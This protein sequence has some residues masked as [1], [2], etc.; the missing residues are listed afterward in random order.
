MESEVIRFMTLCPV[1]TGIINN[2]NS[3]S[4]L[5]N[6]ED[7]TNALTKAGLLNADRSKI[8]GAAIKFL[9]TDAY[10]S[11]YSKMDPALQNFIHWINGHKKIPST[12]NIKTKVAALFPGGI[13][14]LANLPAFRRDR[15]NVILSLIAA[16]AAP[17]SKGTARQQL[18]IAFK[19]I[20]ALYRH[21]QNP[22]EKLEFG[23]L[24]DRTV[25]LPKSIFPLP[26][27][28][29]AARKKK[30][31]LESKKRAKD[32]QRKNSIRSLVAKIS[33]NVGTSQ[34][35]ADAYDKYLVILRSQQVALA[36]NLLS[37]SAAPAG[38]DVLPTPPSLDLVK[39]VSFILPARIADGLSSSAKTTLQRLHID[40]ST[41]DVPVVRK[42]IAAE[43]KSLSNQLHALQSKNA[44]ITFI[45]ST[46]VLAAESV[47]GFELAEISEIV[48]GVPGHCNSGNGTAEE[49][50][51]SDRWNTQGIRPVLYIGDLQK[52]R[53]TLNRY[54]LGDIAHIEN[55]LKG[56]SKNNVLRRLD[57]TVETTVD[58]T[59]TESE[60]EKDL[61]T[62]DQF[63]LQT[64]AAKT[65]TQDKSFDAGLTVSG[66]YGP[67]L[68]ATATA[69]LSL[70][71]TRAQSEQTS[72]NYARDVI[73][74]TVQK[75]K[76][77]NLNS[78]T[79]T[80]T[81]EIK[82]LNKHELDNSTGA[83]HIRGIYQWVN[84]IYR[85]QVMNYG[86]RAML[87][88]TIPDPA[89]FYRYAFTARPSE[90]NS[91]VKPEEP[92]YCRYGTF[93]PLRAEDLNELNYQFWASKYGAADIK[94]YPEE[95]KVIFWN[96][97]LNVEQSEKIAPR[98]IAD[99]GAAP[100]SIPAGYTV[101][102]L[103]YYL[104]IMRNDHQA[105]TAFRD[106]MQVAILIGNVQI[107]HLG[108]SQYNQ[109]NFLIPYPQS[110][111]SLGPIS[112][113]HGQSDTLPVSIAGFSTY[114]TSINVGIKINCQLDPQAREQWQMDTLN[115]ILTAYKNLKAEYD[116]ELKAKEFDNIVS[117]QG[118]NPYFNREIEKTELKKCVLSQLTGQDY[119]Y[120]NAMKYNTPP[121]GYP[122]MDINDAEDEGNYV[123][124]FEQAFEWE[125]M[126]YL[127]YPYFWA[128]RQNWPTLLQV[129]DMDPLFEKF[130]Q[131]GSAR[132][133]VPIRSGFVSSILNF[134]QNGGTPWLLNDAPQV[135][136][137]A[138]EPFISMIEEIKA[139][140]G[141]EF[142]EKNPGTISVTNGSKIVA[143][144]E[145]NFITPDSES[146]IDDESREII[147]EGKSYRIQSV[148][149][150][151]SI[152]LREA[153]GGESKQGIGYY[154]GAKFVGEVW[155]ELI[156][157]ALV[158][159]K[160]ISSDLN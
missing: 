102:L 59:E 143:G 97:S 107:A 100:I 79:T 146:R 90:Q 48:L 31:A 62:Q 20:A 50:L 95:T 112:Y 9:T 68:T 14:S 157:T 129:R 92:G 138:G 23:R 63:T 145:T 18:F 121:P 153:Y 32:E 149:S 135:E 159:L 7:I 120:F 17:Q 83:D 65:I 5:D 150:T 25:L 10:Y 85:L 124:F 53:Q 101:D 142:N 75:I 21:S 39:P 154:L 115:S 54:E 134:I 89:A 104:T 111:R 86:K 26:A 116:R 110:Y 122:Q 109:E 108:I 69:N 47:N 87:E 45:G 36:T 13:A 127:F 98:K 15:R 28:N 114:A 80:T 141:F 152:T 64:Q 148:E 130:L 140:H 147:I 3:V 66:S 43:N 51:P 1:Q 57:K 156:P 113:F 105:T 91:L 160:D 24:L 35:L 58:Q 4:L 61:K 42:M 46:P 103:E 73:S 99:D 6:D 40:T 77:K 131:A 151:T 29:S 30:E 55:V 94:P 52:V 2:N 37:G 67:S 144:V 118:R 70:Q 88:F 106:Q 34:E 126:T 125:N 19:I 133:Q 123:R 155:E 128:N 44:A 16:S 27:D 41:V 132:V 12:E 158:Y 56:E 136:G 76:E 38:D 49:D 119:E 8:A 81:Q 33:S 71:N 11:D 82:V 78:R 74:R 22:N 60:T 139:A 72:T 137:D 84:K 96:K 93:Q 117:I